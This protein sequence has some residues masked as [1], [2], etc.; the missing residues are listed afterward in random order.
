M[1]SKIDLVCMRLM[2]FNGP[3]SVIAF[4][5]NYVDYNNFHVH[6]QPIQFME[7]PKDHLTVSGIDV[8]LA[9]TNSQSSNSITWYH[10]N[11]IID[12]AGPHYDITSNDHR[13]S[14][15]TVR[16]VTTDDQGEYHCCVSEWRNKVRSRS[17]HLKGKIDM[18]L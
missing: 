17:G 16:N 13:T 12:P 3:C 1:I 15:L 10:N 4:K 11:T 2:K 14:I 18:L 6:P 7:E 9:C 5:I 8:T